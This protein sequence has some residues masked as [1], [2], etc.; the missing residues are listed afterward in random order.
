LILSS[1]TAFT[2]LRRSTGGGDE[3]EEMMVGL[4]LAF[5]VAGSLA[6]RIGA[7]SESMSGKL[8]SSSAEDS[9]SSCR[10]FGIVLTADLLPTYLE[11]PGR[12]KLNAVPVRLLA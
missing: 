3:D 10:G 6:F 8:S 1:R 2:F 4:G 9:L 12:D 11:G 5:F 7:G